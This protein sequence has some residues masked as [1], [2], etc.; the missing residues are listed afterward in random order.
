MTENKDK[1]TREEE[2]Q[3]F[4]ELSKKIEKKEKWKL[5]IEILTMLSGTAVAALSAISLEFFQSK[6]IYEEIIKNPNFLSLISLIVVTL[7]LISF[8]PTIIK[9]LSNRNN[10]QDI[11]LKKRVIK[12]YLEQ[13]DKTIIN[14][15]TNILS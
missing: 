7:A 10:R 15:T 6:D 1:N 8:L 12:T 11:S 9:R 5:W 14:P 13:L 2:I 3:V 4:S